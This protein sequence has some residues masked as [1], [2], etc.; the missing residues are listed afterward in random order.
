[1][2]VTIQG[3]TKHPTTVLSEFITAFLGGKRMIRKWKRMILEKDETDTDSIAAP[4][5]LCQEPG[6]G[7]F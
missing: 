5:V 4:A 2:L 1:M 3:G 6:T 7:P